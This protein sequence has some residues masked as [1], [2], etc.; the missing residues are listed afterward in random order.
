MIKSCGGFVVGTASFTSDP[1]SVRQVSGVAVGVAGIM[2]G[3]WVAVAAG[4]GTTGAGGTL[5]DGGQAERPA[6]SRKY[7]VM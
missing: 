3:G 1:G 4:V 2:V 5:T 7:I 6:R